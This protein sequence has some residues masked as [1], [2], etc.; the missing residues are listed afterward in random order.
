[1]TAYK[2]L[3]HPQDPDSS[4][5]DSAALADALREIG[6]IKEPVTVPD[7]VYYPAGEHFLQLLSFLGC[8]PSVELDPPGDA[9]A[10]ETARANGSF[11]HVYLSSTGKLRFRADPRT[12]APRCPAC[13]QPVPGWRTRLAGWR[14]NP[15][16]S[17][18][19]CK[20]CDYS[21]R[22]TDLV[23]RKSAAFAS[24]WIEVR[25]IYPSEA[26]PGAALLNRLRAVSG[27]NWRYIYLQE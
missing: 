9:G 20:A 7:G 3:L 4:P 10:L 17:V 22:L 5:V 25:G 24:S 14:N 16:T 2:L 8:S 19:T 23:F 13:H 6:F 26:V 11:C 12:P 15:A 27:C 21:G 18:W 1:M